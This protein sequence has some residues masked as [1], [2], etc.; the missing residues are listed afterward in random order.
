MQPSPTPSS[1][2]S[3]IQKSPD[4]ANKVLHDT[5]VPSASIGIVQN[6]RIVYTGAFGLASLK[7]EKP[8]EPTMAY[9]IGSISKQFTAAAVLL[10]Q[11]DGKLSLDDKV[12]KYFPDL[13]R[14]GD[15]TPP[16]PHDHD[17][18]L[19]GLRPAGLQH[20]RPGT[21]PPTHSKP[22]TTGPASPSTSIPAPTGSTPTTN[23]VLVALIVQ[24]VS[25][26][27][28]YQFLRER[29]LTPLALEG[30]INT[31]TDRSK[32][33]VTGY[34]SNALAPPREQPLEAD[35]WYFGDGELAMPAA[36]LLKWD[37]S[38]INRSLLSPASYAAMET[39]FPP[40]RWP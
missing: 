13:T 39:P 9:P 3:L 23:Y 25:G 6:G 5:G 18:R 1:P 14:A 27:P 22:S 4:I 19:P 31:Y 33:R 29:I 32:L 30:V 16:Q 26:E 24:K 34:A 28:F 12:S 20:P 11:Q 37:L 17:L 38:I 21:N 7:P 36:T 40:H 2:P 8:A 10:L 35:G 15:V